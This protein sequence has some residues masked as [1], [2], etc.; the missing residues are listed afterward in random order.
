MK[1]LGIIGCVLGITLLGGIKLYQEIQLERK[2]EALLQ[3]V[4]DE[5]EE[6]RPEFGG[7]APDSYKAF[8]LNRLLTKTTKL[9]IKSRW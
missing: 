2:C 5:A 6:L 7:D 1:Q 8:V 9:G 4:Q 3:E